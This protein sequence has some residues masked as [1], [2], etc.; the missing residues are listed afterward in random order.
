MDT[1]IFALAT[2]YST[3]RSHWSIQINFRAQKKTLSTG[4]REGRVHCC[5]ESRNASLLPRVPWV[6]WSCS[7]RRTIVNIA[8]PFVGFKN[9]RN[10]FKGQKTFG[11]S[12]LWP[13][14]NWRKNLLILLSILLGVLAKNT[15]PFLFICDTS[16]GGSATFR[17]SPGSREWKSHNGFG[18]SNGF[19]LSL[20]LSLSLLEV[21]PYFQATELTLEL[22]WGAR[23]SRLSVCL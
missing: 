18:K 1:A 22:T 7:L 20:S 9:T 11:R 19:S 2:A 8:L 6:N 10:A 12:W 4:G 5:P 21:L 17:Y 3:R 13:R 14:E 15:C 16:T 23:S